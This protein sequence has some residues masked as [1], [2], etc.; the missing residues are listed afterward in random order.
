[1]THAF[2]DFGY[3]KVILKMKL[4]LR[5]VLNSK[6]LELLKVPSFLRNF[7]LGQCSSTVTVFKS[8]SVTSSQCPSLCSKV[9]D[10]STLLIWHVSEKIIYR[11]L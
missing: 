7:R 6:K 4:V 1:M 10:G 9:S 2:I 3:T 8:V 5:G 11:C